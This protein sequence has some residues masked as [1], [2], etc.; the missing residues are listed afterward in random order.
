MT[1]AVFYGGAVVVALALA[2]ELRFTEATLALGRFV[3]GETEGRGH[4][5]AITP[6]ASSNIGLAIY[7]LSLGVVVLAFVR[8]GLLLGIGMIAGF[9]VVVSIVKTLLPR[10]GSQHFQRLLIKS[11]CNRYADYVRDGDKLRAEAM[12]YML[13]KA[14][15]PVNERGE[16]GSAS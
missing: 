6:P 15:L 4:Q 11:M 3:A 14:G 12:A 13:N 7:G 8:F 1:D 10:P 16:S 5:D 9:L 2:Y